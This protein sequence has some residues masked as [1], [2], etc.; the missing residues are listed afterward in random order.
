MI[1]LKEQIACVKRELTMRGIVYP[2]R[3]AVG[4]MKP[5]E[6]EREVAAMRAVLRTLMDLEAGETFRRDGTGNA[7]R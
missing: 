3:V 5:V 1:T 6:A 4:K 7:D 2:R